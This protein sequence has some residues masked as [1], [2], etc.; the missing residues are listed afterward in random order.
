MVRNLGDIQTSAAIRYF[1]SRK[2]IWD[3][4]HERYA[5]TSNCNKEQVLA[6]LSQKHYNGQPM[7]KYLPE[8]K[9]ADA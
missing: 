3:A 5:S 2:T 7:D 4:L 9:F 6:A 8:F 1:E